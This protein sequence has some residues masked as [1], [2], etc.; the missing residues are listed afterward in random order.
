MVDL[1]WPEQALGCPIRA[2]YGVQPETGLVRTPMESGLARAR[3][4][5]PRAPGRVSASW[6]MSGT[7][8]RYYYAWV[9]QKAGYGAAW[10]TVNLDY[11]VGRQ[12][13][14]AR[15]VEAP[16]ISRISSRRWRVDM[17]LEVLPVTFESLEELELVSIYG[18]VPA[19]ESLSAAAAGLPP[20]DDAAILS[21]EVRWHEYFAV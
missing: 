10:F 19:L 8:L 14:T 12:P 18:G 5:Y 16:K 21:G 13:V 3:R 9:E 17:I 7:Q 11:G 2:G 6:I 4:R 1:L 20:V 15:I